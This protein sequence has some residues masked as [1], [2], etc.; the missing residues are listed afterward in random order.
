MVD[1]KTKGSIS[2]SIFF[3]FFF[4]RTPFLVSNTK[5]TCQSL[6]RHVIFFFNFLSK[7]LLHLIIIISNNNNNNSKKKKQK[8]FESLTHK[9]WRTR[10]WIALYY[11]V[12]VISKKDE[13]RRRREKKKKNR[14]I[15][16]SSS[17]SSIASHIHTHR[18][19]LSNIYYHV[20][21]GCFA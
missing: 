21:L 1:E 7:T 13:G 2:Q 3:F 10:P 16:L 14:N 9:V 18:R 19:F 6:K 11:S 12:I 5:Y 20:S 17:R 8:E 15:H 4:N